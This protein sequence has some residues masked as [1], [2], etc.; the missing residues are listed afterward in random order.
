MDDSDCDSEPGIPLKRKQR[1]SRTTFSAE[2][3][4]AL[5]AAFHKSQ[6]PDVYFREE[7]AQST[8]LTEARVQVWFS[9]RRARW[10]KQTGNGQTTPGSGIMPHHPTPP[11]T[12][13]GL[14]SSY[15]MHHHHHHPSMT[16]SQIFH[17][18]SHVYSSVDAT[19]GCG[20]R[21]RKQAGNT[22]VTGHP[23]HSVSSTGTSSVYPTVHHP[24]YH[25][26]HPSMTS[27]H[28]IPFP[29]SHVYS[30][31]DVPGYSSLTSLGQSGQFGQQT[32]SS[33]SGYMSPV[34][35]G[36]TQGTSPSSSSSIVTGGGTGG[37]HSSGTTVG[38]SSSSSHA[39]HNAAS[40]H[41]HPH[42]MNQT[43]QWSGVPTEVASYS[44][45]KLNP[46]TRDDSTS[47]SSL[48]T[49]PSSLASS[50]SFLKNTHTSSVPQSSSSSS[51]VGSSSTSTFAGQGVHPSSHSH[52]AHHLH[53]PTHHH[54]PYGMEHGLQAALGFSHYQQSGIA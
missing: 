19:I 24:T 10:R 47:T 45:T 39:P 41:P 32:S 46:V 36:V 50:S 44:G 1:R 51:S 23:H 3:L 38:Y 33:S 37:S 6:Y 18:P 27:T 40:H 43:T 54:V 21:W 53:H 25:S 52:S 20:D 16:S 15:S 30:G 26:H 48:S 42:H 11:V 17:P 34:Y 28:H 5:E 2:Q 35:T 9:N 13:P 12:P 8:K 49:I 22:D 14:T 7:L 4:D 31:V 29:P